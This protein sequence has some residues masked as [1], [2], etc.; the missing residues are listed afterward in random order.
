MR[1][2]VLNTLNEEKAFSV[3]AFSVASGISTHVF[4]A[5]PHHVLEYF[6]EFS[7]GTDGA[8]SGLEHIFICHTHHLLPLHSL[9]CVTILV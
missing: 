2:S 8:D 1:A 5:I 4:F 7:S 6:K 9:K 3:H